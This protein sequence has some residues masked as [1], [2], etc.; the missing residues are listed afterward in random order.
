M[1]PKTLILCIACYAIA[2]C[3]NNTSVNGV[4]DSTAKEKATTARTIPTKEDSILLQ[5]LADS[6]FALYPVTTPASAALPPDYAVTIYQHRDF[7]GVSN[8]LGYIGELCWREESLGI[9]T[10]GL[11]LSSL[12]VPFGMSATLSGHWACEGHTLRTCGPGDFT[13]VGDNINDKTRSIKVHN[14]SIFYTACASNVVGN[15]FNIHESYPIPP[16]Y[17][18]KWVETTKNGKAKWSARIENNKF[19]IDIWVS[20]DGS[21]FGASSWCGVNAWLEKI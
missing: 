4:S 11:A 13:Y 19:F 2:S 3:N 17:T 21:L 10:G 15:I 16:G 20:G 7:Q 1:K 18:V 8:K 6:L 12:K 14:V 9:G 5:K